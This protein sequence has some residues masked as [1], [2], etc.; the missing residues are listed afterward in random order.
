[1]WDFLPL[2]VGV[3]FP[4]RVPISLTNEWFHTLSCY[5]SFVWC[6]YSIS[7]LVY[8]YIMALE[9]FPSFS[10]EVLPSNLYW[11][12][13]TLRPS[14]RCVSYFYVQVA[15]MFVS[16]CGIIIPFSNWDFYRVVQ[17]DGMV[18]AD[19]WR[20]P[21]LGDGAVI[22][23]VTIGGTGVST[24]GG[25]GSPTFCAVDVCITLVCV[26]CFS[27]G[28]LTWLQVVLGPTTG[29]HQFL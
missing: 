24:L 28:L 25:D 15:R 1:M 16:S 10:G 8:G 22:L 2:V 5:A 23:H 6:L 4:V 20:L 13:V 18:G 27:G 29:F 19:I 17:V 11:P 7:N 12:D 3:I 26:P 14:N 9:N 21:I